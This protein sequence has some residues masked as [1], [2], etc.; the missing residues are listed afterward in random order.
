VRPIMFALISAN[1]IN[2]FFNWLLIQGHWAPP[3][4]T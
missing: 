1:L 3:P 4:R 2:S